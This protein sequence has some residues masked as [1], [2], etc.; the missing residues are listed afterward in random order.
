MTAGGITSRGKETRKGGVIAKS[1]GEVSANNPSVRT[2]KVT[3]KAPASG[4][5]RALTLHESPTIAHAIFTPAVLL[6]AVEQLSAN[7]VQFQKNAFNTADTLRA[8]NKVRTL[9]FL[10]ILIPL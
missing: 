1:T 8:I 5:S 6:V 9:M 4:S 10:V 3:R 2:D 7:A